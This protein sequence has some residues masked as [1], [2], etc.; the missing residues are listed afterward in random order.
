MI[1]GRARNKEE[2]EAEAYAP[3]PT[4]ELRVI[5]SW[6]AGATCLEGKGQ[7]DAPLLMR[8]P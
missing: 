4:D 5:K 8:N 6:A 1:L 2:G 7:R 3:N